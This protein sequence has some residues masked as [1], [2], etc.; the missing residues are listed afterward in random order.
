MDNSQKPIINIY[1]TVTIHTPNGEEVTLKVKI[2]TGAFR[3][4]IDLALAEKLDLY[5]PDNT[6]GE[7]AVRSA[8][9][10][11]KRPVVEVSY[12][13]GGITLN[14]NA[15]IS[16]RSRLRFPMIIGRRDLKQFLISYNP[17]KETDKGP[18]ELSNQG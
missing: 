1:E 9:G 15:S 13:L 11:H 10:K 12:D 6:I 4:S 16:D 3:T 17:Q 5:H 18:L 2:D 8:L 14:T 7:V